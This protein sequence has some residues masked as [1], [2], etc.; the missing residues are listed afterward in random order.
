[1]KSQTEFIVW[2]M[3]KQFK[4]DYKKTRNWWKNIWLIKKNV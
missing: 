4:R 2:R 1:M 3:R